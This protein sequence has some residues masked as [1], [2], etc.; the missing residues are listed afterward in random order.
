MLRVRNLF[1]EMAAEGKTLLVISH[2]Y[3]FLL[4]TCQRVLCLFDDYRS[5]CF[6]VTEQTKEHLADVMQM[7]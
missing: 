1:Q 7:R 4:A 5:E 3:E 6:A 2:D